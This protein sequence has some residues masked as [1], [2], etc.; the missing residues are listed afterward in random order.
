M[1]VPVGLQ[2]FEYQE[3]GDVVSCSSR[4]KAGGNDGRTTPHTLAWLSCLEFE[5]R[6]TAWLLDCRPQ[7]RDCQSD[8]LASLSEP[9]LKK[10]G[11]AIVRGTGSS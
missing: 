11:H 9:P 8:E 7:E 4:K 10:R 6:R 1:V 3:A 5:L 2:R